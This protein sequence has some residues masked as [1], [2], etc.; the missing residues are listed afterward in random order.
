MKGIFIKYMKKIGLTI[1]K[2]APLH[3]G[4][5]YLINTALEQVDELYI[6]VYE[7]NVID[8]DIDT[9]IKWISKIFKNKNIKIVK[10]LNPPM[11]YGMDKESIKIQVNY[12]LEIIKKEGSPKITHFFSSEEYGKFV[13]NALG[14]ENVVVDKKRINI[15]INATN[16]RNDLEKYKIYLST[17][18]Y[19]DLKNTQNN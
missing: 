8:I 15:P 2:F 7:T 17:N 18:V 6:F 16:I 19:N 11:Q 13:A 12:I 9:R 4:H 1:G 3:K 14:A 5:E 10:A